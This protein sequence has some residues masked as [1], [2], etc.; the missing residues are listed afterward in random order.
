ML[1]FR[2]TRDKP[3]V[4]FSFAGYPFIRRLLKMGGLPSNRPG[5][6]RLLAA[7]AY[8]PCGGRTGVGPSPHH[9]CRVTFDDARG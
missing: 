1:D 7:M 2:V 5:Q 6:G 8:N 9:R 4:D 3:V